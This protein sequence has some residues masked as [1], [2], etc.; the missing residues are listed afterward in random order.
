MKLVQY[1]LL[2]K[3]LGIFCYNRLNILRKNYTAFFSPL[4]LVKM[5]DA[6]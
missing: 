2:H 5:T 6:Y 4:M 1:D 3:L